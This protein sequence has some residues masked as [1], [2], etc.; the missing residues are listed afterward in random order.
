[1][2]EDW[3]EWKSSASRNLDALVVGWRTT[4][5]RRPTASLV[6]AKMHRSSASSQAAQK[7]HLVASAVCSGATLDGFLRRV[8]DLVYA[9]DLVFRDLCEPNVL[10]MP[11]GGA[12]L[13]DIGWCGTVGEAQ[14]SSGRRLFDR[15]YA[16]VQ[17][18][19]AQGPG[20]EGARRASP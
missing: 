20:Q 19:T 17:V 8:V 18:R 5:W 11:G 13:V 14:Y 10:T 3:M 16:R 15:G 6:K 12:F 4:C 9:R 2:N 1:M 7:L